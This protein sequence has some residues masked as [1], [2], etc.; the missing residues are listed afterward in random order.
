MSY[1]REMTHGGEWYPIDET[2]SQMLRGAF[3]YAQ[4]EEG[5]REN[6][7]GVIAPHSCYSVCVKTAAKSYVRID[8]D[9]YDRIFILGTCHNLFLNSCLVSDASEVVTPFGN[10]EVDVDLC[11]KLCEELPETFKLTS[12]DV[13]DAEH[14]LEMQYPLVKWVFKD[15]RIKIVPIIIGSLSETTSGEIG[16]VLQPYIMAD[17]TLFIISSDF[18]HWGEVFGF[19]EMG[20]VRKKMTDDERV[21]AF[22]AKA[23]GIIGQFNSMHFRFHLEFIKA[24]IC[25]GYAIC[26]M[27]E[28][29]NGS[30]ACK[31]YARSVLAKLRSPRDFTISYIA[32]GF[33]R[34]PEVTEEGYDGECEGNK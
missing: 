15:R 26:L 22:D 24:A 13:D 10:I 12:K 34:V 11:R 21:E 8:P 4:A 33:Y 30:F 16:P 9:A 29:M 20:D 31:Q 3:Y 19:R 23:M 17:R 18:T 1:V 27:L 6:L 28:I 7:V 25:G 2:L 32:A 14:S 5:E